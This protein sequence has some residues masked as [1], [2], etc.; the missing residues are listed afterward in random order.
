[1]HALGFDEIFGR[2][3]HFYLS[4]RAPGFASGY[5][6]VHQLILDQG[7][8]L[9]ERATA[10]RRRA[11][12]PARSTPFVGGELPVRLRAWDGSEAGPVDAPAW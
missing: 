8:G 5:L 9:H 2:M 4:T 11:S 10:A 6:D 3:W 1:M 7:A 12:P